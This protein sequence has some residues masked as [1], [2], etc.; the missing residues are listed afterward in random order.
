MCDIVNFQVGNQLIRNIGNLLA[1]SRFFTGAGC[2]ILVSIKLCIVKGGL[3]PC[4]VQNTN[5]K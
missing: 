4:S 3:V 1:I 5:I 2:M